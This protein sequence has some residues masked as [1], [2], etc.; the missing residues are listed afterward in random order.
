[1]EKDIKNLI[2]DE[3]ALIKANE[4]VDEMVEEENTNLPTVETNN[5]A[6][7]PDSFS[8]NTAVGIINTTK[9]K[10]LEEAEKKINQDKIIDKHSTKLSKVADD[11]MAVETEKAAI[12]VQKKDASNKAEKQEIKNKLI[13]L[14]NEAKRLRKAERHKNRL[15]KISIKQEKSNKR[16]E[17]LESTLKPLGYD[18]VPNTI[19]LHIL[20]MLVGIKAFG[21]IGLAR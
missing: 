6:L 10:I 17:M 4:E 3:I 9:D 13:I 8:G 21:E 1:M 7:M 20:L 16:W 12:E 2:D 5:N 11:L 18:Y 19:A 15:Q 14:K